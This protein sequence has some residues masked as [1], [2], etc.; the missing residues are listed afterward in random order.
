MVMSRSKIRSI[1]FF[2]CCFPLWAYADSGTDEIGKLKV[3]LFLGSNDPEVDAGP[4]ATSVAESVASHLRVS[5]STNFSHYH[6]LG[7]DLVSI[8]RTYENWAR[9][10]KPSEA[11][12]M[13]FEP[14]GKADGKL[15][16]LD[17]ELWQAKQKIMKSPR[18]ALTV[19][20]PL[21]IKGPQWRGGF[22]II[23]VTLKDLK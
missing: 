1:F 7:T 17:L 6:A 2:V 12:M 23:S 4:N 8:Y 18:T 16:K 19:D 11:I 9:P 13:S 10:L 20:K 5:E 22:L 21:L 14:V 3:S 15:I